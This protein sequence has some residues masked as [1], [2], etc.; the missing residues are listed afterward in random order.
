MH[1]KLLQEAAMAVTFVMMSMVFNRFLSLKL[2]LTNKCEQKNKKTMQERMGSCKEIEY[3]P[4]ETGTARQ[5]KKIK[6]K[7]IC[8]ICNS[9]KDKDK[10]KEEKQRKGKKS[11]LQ[12]RQRQIG[13]RRGPANGSICPPCLP[14]C[15]SSHNTQYKTIQIHNT[16]NTVQYIIHTI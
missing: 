15:V 3:D 7:K 5:E 9:D 4:G 10:D 8:L 1:R 11:D 13:G 16:Q 6:E 2:D 12:L 14:A